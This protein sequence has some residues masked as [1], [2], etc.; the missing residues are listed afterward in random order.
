MKEP[1]EITVKRPS[2]EYEAI[3]FHSREEA[4][5]AAHRETVVGKSELV[6]IRRL[7]PDEGWDA[8]GRPL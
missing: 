8:E 7:W 4:E 6:S 5:L 3:P 1:T 2:G